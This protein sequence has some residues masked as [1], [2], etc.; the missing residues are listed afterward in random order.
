MKILVRGTN[1]IGDAVMSIPALRELRRIFPEDRITLHTRSWADGLFEEASFIDDIVTYEKHRWRVKDVL[2]NSQFLREDRYDLAILLPNSFEAALTAFL[3]KIP[4][5]IGYNKDARGLLLTDPIAVP[6]WKGRRHEAFYYIELVRQI[7]RL[8]LG[9]ETVGREVPDALLEVSDK[10][11][12]IA[13]K[14]LADLGCDPTKETIVLGVGSANSAAK[15]WPAA[16]YAAIAEM[17]SGR[18]DANVVLMGSKDEA[19]IA[20]DVEKSTRSPIFNI[21]GRTSLAEGVAILSVVDLTVSNDMG[22]AHLAA[23]VQTNTLVIFGPTDPNIT[24]PF[25]SYAH[26]ITAG[27]DCSPCHLRDCPIDHRCMT[28]ITPQMVFDRSVSILERDG[29]AATE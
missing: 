19:Q 24:R 29:T 11:R 20:A 4:R 28:R 23:A 1:W 2:D 3:S 17:F 7:E 27:A 12:S 25:S 5:R 15:R 14:Y 16:S 10:R 21:A 18:R 22:L 26:I 9:R 8:I 13:R 6:E